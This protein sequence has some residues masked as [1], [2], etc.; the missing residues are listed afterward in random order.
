M[1]HKKIVAALSVAA[2]ALAGCGSKEVAGQSTG[3]PA[4]TSSAASTAPPTSTAAASSA[5][6]ADDSGTTPTGTTLSV[7]QTATVL[8]AIKDLSKESTKLQVTAVSAKKGSIGDL[9]NFNLDA[10]TKASEPYYITMKFTNAGPKPMAPSGI[11]GLIEAHNSAGD[12]MSRLSLLGDFKQ[13]DGTPPDTLA[14]GQSFT[15]CD[16]YI[17]PTGQNL[18]QVVFAFYLDTTRTEITWKTS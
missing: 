14:V 6:P 15:E 11:F 12:E 18:G 5:P 8:Y 9:K 2:L 3:D 13:C 7:G 4:A 1:F 16:V 17:A 10:Q